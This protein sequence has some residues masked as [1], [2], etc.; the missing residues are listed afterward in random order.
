ML[1]KR[2][3]A[4]GA[5]KAATHVEVKHSGLSPE[6]NFSDRLVDQAVKEGWMVVGDK[7]VTIKTDA[8][9][10]NFALVRKPGY[11]CKS[12]GESIPVSEANW[13]R[14]RLANDQRASAEAK[15]WLAGK[16]LPANDYDITAAYHCVLDA[17][18]HAKYRAVSPGG[19][20]PAVAAH[21]LEA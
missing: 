11:F 6:Q 12:T 3:F 19:G 5:D 2:H 13:L 1:L 7:T 16:G 15:A 20:I 8:D 17:K 14:F 4:N 10:L 21:T 18:Q 9:P